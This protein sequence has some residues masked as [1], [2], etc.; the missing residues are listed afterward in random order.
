[1]KKQT[2]YKILSFILQ[3]NTKLCIKEIKLNSS[4][5]KELSPYQNNIPKIKI[6]KQLKLLK[7]KKINLAK[8]F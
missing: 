2:I 8:L 6:I 7:Q 3:K 5:S 1:M 4:H